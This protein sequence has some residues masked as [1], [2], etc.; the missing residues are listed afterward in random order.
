MPESLISLNLSG[1]LNAVGTGVS[2]RVFCK[3][4]IH[5]ASRV[6]HYLFT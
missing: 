5:S 3:T 6:V 4:A 1:S 2:L